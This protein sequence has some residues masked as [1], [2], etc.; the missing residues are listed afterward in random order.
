MHLLLALSA[1]APTIG[2]HLENLVL[3]GF[4]LFILVLALALLSFLFD[5]ISKTCSASAN[6]LERRAARRRRRRHTCLKKYYPPARTSHLRIVPPPDDSL[7]R[8]ALS[9]AAEAHHIAQISPAR[10]SS[11]LR[12][13]NPS[14]KV[15]R[16]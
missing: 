2:D 5:K 1:S 6:W 15:S 10:A 8:N 9:R 14:E 4:G 12:L 7:A 11:N 3:L 16:K 13:V